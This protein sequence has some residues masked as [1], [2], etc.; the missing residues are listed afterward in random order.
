[1]LPDDLNSLAV[2]VLS[3]RLIPSGRVGVTV[4]GYSGETIAEIVTRIVAETPVPLGARNG[5]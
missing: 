2:A 1:M 5:N 3:H 4:G